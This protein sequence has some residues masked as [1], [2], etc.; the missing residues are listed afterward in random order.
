MK[1]PHATLLLA[2]AVTVVAQ[3]PTTI[4]ITGVLPSTV[5]YVELPSV[6][7][8]VTPHVNDGQPFERRLR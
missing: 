2:L 1:L 5:M 8:L 3:G 7:T 6:T 4:N